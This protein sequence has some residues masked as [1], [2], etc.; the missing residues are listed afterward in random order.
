[1]SNFQIIL[2][3]LN[4]ISGEYMDKRDWGFRTKFDVSW[5]YAFV[6]F[7][8]FFIFFYQ[9]GVC[10]IVC[11]SDARCRNL[12]T[13]TSDE[14]AYCQFNIFHVG[15]CHI[16]KSIMLINLLNNW[17]CKNV[18]NE[19]QKDER[20][21][22]RERQR[23]TSILMC[24]SPPTCFSLSLSESICKCCS[25]FVFLYIFMYVKLFPSFLSASHWSDWGAWGP[26]TAT[27]GYYGRHTRHR[28]CIGQGSC[29]GSSS[30]TATC[31]SQVCPGKLSEDK[32]TSL[33]WKCC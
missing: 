3:L 20:E 31:N 29:V 33:V 19:E 10:G 32:T 15:C 22:D 27:C 13:V 12:M 24:F 30:L 18:H 21:R 17:S 9:T 6:C 16:R 5:V 7:N 26:C 11:M 28:T 4:T 23:V 25:I 2:V 14:E 8:L 1:M